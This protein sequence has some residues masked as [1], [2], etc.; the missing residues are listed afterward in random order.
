MEAQI[1]NYRRSRHHQYMN[2]L[3]ISPKGFDNKEKAETL[4]G[5]VVIFKTQ[6]DKEIKGKVT[7]AHGNSGCI[8]ASFE[9][10]IPGQALGKTVEVQ[11][12]N[13]E[14]R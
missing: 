13:T 4:V 3:I 7:A 14:K 6:T 2:Q 10:G 8:R 12:G 9:V 1:V 5:K 11:D